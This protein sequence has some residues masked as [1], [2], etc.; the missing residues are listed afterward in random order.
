MFCKM[1]KLR[2][3][4]ICHMS[5]RM[6]R[7]HLRLK[8]CYLK[9]LIKRFLGMTPYSYSD[10]GTWNTISFK[11]YE[12]Y[13]GSVEIHAVIPHPGMKDTF[14]SFEYN[15]IFYHCFN[16]TEGIKNE[17]KI[18]RERISSIVRSVRPN[19]ICII[20]A[21]APFYSLAAL[22]VDVE[23]IPMVIAMQTALSDPDFTKLYPIDSN[24]YQRMLSSEQ[25]VFKHTKYI[26]S[27]VEWHRELAKRINPT[28]SF[29]RYYFCTDTSIS[30]DNVEKEFDFVYWASNI[31]KAGTDALMAFARAHKK[32]SDLTLNMVGSYTKEYYGKVVDFLQKE[33]LE[34]NVVLSGYFPSHRDALKQVQ[35]SRFALV[36]IKVDIISSTIREAALMKM[37]IVT[38][39]TKGTPSMNKEKQC[40]LLSEIDDYEDMANNMLKLVND[41]NLR[42]TL[43]SNAYDYAKKSFDNELGANININMFMAVYENFHSGTT[44]PDSVTSTWL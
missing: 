44:M 37:P 10:Y 40:V 13:T 5:N 20:G 42:M 14:S 29:V 21:E 22:D 1:E 24:V 27:D 12:K 16:Q 18:N 7:E 19:V 6:I 26:A 3:A 39:S 8:S 30:I 38:F 15:G 34:R 2:V 9:N 17:Y 36:P 33:G 25:R 31:E 28:A 32:D 23:K 35:K 11:E 41:S 43:S 4:I